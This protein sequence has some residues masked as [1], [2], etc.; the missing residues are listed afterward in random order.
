MSDKIDQIL[1]KLTTEEVDALLA[2]I[3]HARDKNVS[4]PAK[5]LRNC[6]GLVQDSETEQNEWTTIVRGRNKNRREQ[7]RDNTSAR[8]NPF[9]EIPGFPVSFNN[10]PSD[11]IK[12]SV[13]IRKAIK[14]VCPEVKIKTQKTFA[15]YFRIVVYP[16]DLESS[17]SLLNANF[18]GSP[19]Q[20]VTVG[21]D[22]KS[23]SQF[24]VLI[25]G[26]EPCIPDNEIKEEL[27]SQ[28]IQIKSLAR[29][30][31]PGTESPTFKVKVDLFD[32]KP[33]ER[34]LAN[35]VYIG[36]RRH[37]AIDFKPLPNVLVCFNCQDFDH[38]SKDCTKNTV[39]VKCG[40]EHKVAECTREN[41]LCCHCFGFHS[42]AYKGCPV[43]REKQQELAKKREAEN[44]TVLPPA[45]RVQ[46]QEAKAKEPDYEKIVNVLTE[47]VFLVFDKFAPDPNRN[48][49][50][51]LSDLC[52]IT[53]E[54]MAHHTKIKCQGPDTFTHCKGRLKELGFFK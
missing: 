20:G 29:M 5:R 28:G 36:Y 6:S 37:K 12:N 46:V 39:C 13:A 25:T 44:K 26:V 51:F 40:E 31:A 38:H 42:G 53:S 47:V 21:K 27:E 10:V 11:I 41:P 17:E 49:S 16:A 19:L 32:S 43:Y 8:E 30:K 22:V 4:Q 54:S 7:N 50:Q 24:S 2:R 48:Q 35:G 3:L 23:K 18:E 14:N 15:D 52:L 1:E 33:K 9:Q 45:P 34:I